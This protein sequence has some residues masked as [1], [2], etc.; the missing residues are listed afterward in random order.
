MLLADHT[1]WQS[2]N[3][4]YTWNQIPSDQPFLAFYLHNYSSDRAYL[5]TS[6]TK[7]YYT[8]DTGRSWHSLDAPAVPNNFGAQVIQFHPQSDNLLWVGIV[9]CTGTGGNCHAEA[10]F[11]R[12]NGRNWHEVEKYVRNCAWARDSEL[13][14]DSTQILCE[15]YK[16]KQGNQRLFQNNPLELVSGTNYFQKK[17]KLFDHIVGFAKFSEYLLVAEVSFYSRV[18]TFPY[19]SSRSYS[20]CQSDEPSISR[21]HWMD[22]RSPLASSHLTCILKP[23]QVSITLCFQPLLNFHVPYRRILF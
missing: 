7:F 14:I 9:D 11:S 21:C 16:D 19:Y 5:I 10:F 4:G 12:D 20:T 6:T 2:S 1:I 15:S 18:I 3:E 13:K 8:T 22:G 17:T 23:M